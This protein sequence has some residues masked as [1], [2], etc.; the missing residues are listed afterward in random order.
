MCKILRSNER[1][2]KS[3]KAE[4]QDA[5]DEALD[6]CRSQSMRFRQPESERRLCARLRR[7]DVLTSIGIVRRT[8]SCTTRYIIHLYVHSL[9][10][11]NCTHKCGYTLGIGIS[12]TST[13]LESDFSQ[14]PGFHSSCPLPGA[15]CRVGLDKEVNARAFLDGSLDDRLPIEAAMGS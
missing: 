15:P 6:P 9:D 4:T 3:S 12:A 14:R 5:S 1:T 11:P 13:S 8:S 7:P 10:L 2:S